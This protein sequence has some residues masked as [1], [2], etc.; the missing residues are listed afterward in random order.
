[1]SS[2][3]D[4]EAQQ[5][6]QAAPRA[7]AGA[8]FSLFLI[9]VEVVTARKEEVGGAEMHEM[10][11]LGPHTRAGSVANSLRSA[12]TGQ[13]INDEAQSVISQVGGVTSIWPCCLLPRRLFCSC[14]R[15]RRG[16]RCP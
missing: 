3:I 8:C 4:L 16:K 6:A 13:D 15:I 7:S 12:S 11:I 14:Y 10:G 2:V 1:M 9:T 5:V